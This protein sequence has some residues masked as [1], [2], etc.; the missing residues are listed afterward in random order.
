MVLVVV[1]DGVLLALEVHVG[2]VDLEILERALSW[3]EGER[4]VEHVA[5]GE[6]GRGAGVLANAKAQTAV[7]EGEVAKR[8]GED[9]GKPIA[10]G[11]ELADDTLE[12][13]LGLESGLITADRRDLEVG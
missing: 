8:A 1:F 4:L 3:S 5:D 7:L 9:L 10:I 11:L 13:E 6:S 12:N 2:E